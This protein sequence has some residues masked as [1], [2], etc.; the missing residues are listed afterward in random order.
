[1][2]LWLALIGAALVAALVLLLVWLLK[3]TEGAYLG[4]AVVTALYDRFADRY[5]R[6]K[7]FDDA[8][9]AYFIGQPVA[10]YLAQRATPSS[11]QPWLL[12]VA[13]GT[14]RF[15]LAALQAAEGRCRTIA[16]DLSLPMLR[17]AQ[18][19]LDQAGWR[20]VVYLQHAAAPLPFGEGQF[21][22]VACLEA[23]EFMP[24]PRAALAELFRVARPG[25]LILV[26]RRIGRDARL[27]PGKAF[28]R[29]ELG[30]LLRSL[31]AGTVD[32]RPWQVD[33][34]LALALK[35]GAD[36][37]PVDVLAWTSLVRCP[38]CHVD[39]PLAEADGLACTRCGWGL[40]AEGGIWR[41]ATGDRL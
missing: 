3:I 10:R 41:P 21:D 5:D 4:P 22:V 33:Y 28:G 26:T 2:A 8:D 23:L 24:D 6:I 14:G 37:E 30:D 13:A 25:A 32:I 38:V 36:A 17:K 35:T 9:E 1:M 29:L 27:M 15:S 34:D 18:G 39:Q 19:K 12:D 11:C 20:E 7:Q 31:G 40:R 16:L